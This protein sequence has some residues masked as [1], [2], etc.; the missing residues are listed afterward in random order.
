MDVTHKNTAASCS[1]PKKP[2]LEFLAPLVMCTSVINYK[3]INVIFNMRN[4]NCPI[5]FSGFAVC[6]QNVVNFIFIMM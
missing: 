1:L 3:A 4:F 2:F 5:N 6:V